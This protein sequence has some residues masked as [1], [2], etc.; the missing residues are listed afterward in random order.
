[1]STGPK[2]L[3]ILSAILALFA[4]SG[5]VKVAR[6]PVGATVLAFGDSLT[7]GVGVSKTDSYPSVLARLTGLNVINAGVSGELTQEG[8]GRLPALLDETSPNLL[9][10]AEGGND[11]LRGYDLARTRNNLASMIE[12]AQERYIPI[13]LLGVPEKNIF[14]SSAPLYRE[15]AEE[16]QVV[17]DGDLL[18]GLLKSTAHKSDAIHFNEAGYRLMAEGIHELLID[19]GAL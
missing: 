6:L 2:R 15:L 11:I 10:L 13:I 17:F 7:S 16:Y 8:L 14:S 12:K 5:D 1:V 19:S 3:L 18:S 9:I 4:C